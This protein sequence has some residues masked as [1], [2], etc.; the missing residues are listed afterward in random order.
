MNQN[1]VEEGLLYTFGDTLRNWHRQA[2]LCTVVRIVFRGIEGNSLRM[3][4]R[5]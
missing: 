3:V 1:S 5:D 4:I 2:S